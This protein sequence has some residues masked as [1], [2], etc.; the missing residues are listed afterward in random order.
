MSVISGKWHQQVK[1]KMTSHFPKTNSH[2]KLCLQQPTLSL[3]RSHHSLLTSPV[4]AWSKILM[5]M[6][7]CLSNKL[8]RNNKICQSWA[9]FLSNLRKKVVSFNS[10]KKSV[11]C[12]CNKIREWPNNLAH[13]TTLLPAKT[14]SIRIREPN[15]LLMKSRVTVY[16]QAN[17]SI[18]HFS[19]LQIR[20]KK[21]SILHKHLRFTV[22]FQYSVLHR[23]KTFSTLAQHS[24]INRIKHIKKVHLPPCWNTE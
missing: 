5:R 11:I 10:C 21:Q 4:P 19:N 3:K 2:H 6:Q 16:L 23:T 24:L 17:Q 12:N 22:I 8:L 7:V 15:L 9:T 13:K 20:N 18:S 14:T 1:S